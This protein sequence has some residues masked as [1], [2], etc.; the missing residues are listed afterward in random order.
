VVGVLAALVERQASGR[1]QVVDVAIVNG[2]PVL[3]QAMWAM[4][5]DG[6]W[7]DQRGENIFDGSAPFYCT[8][9]CAD[10]RFVAVGALEPQFF[11][12]LLQLLG[13]DPENIGPQRDRSSWPAL[14]EKLATA[15][16]TRTRDEWA[17]IFATSDACVTPVLTMTEAMAD[18]HLQAREVF[19]DVDGIAQPAPA[20]LLSRTPAAPP[21]APH[22]VGLS[23]TWRPPSR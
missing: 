2:V 12:E 11:A 4:R 21:A 13:I 8:Y 17:E 14:R 23:Q 5:A 1:G 6:R 3:S 18:P 16:L 7:V 9:P 10:G 15:F 22:T 19:V 20:P